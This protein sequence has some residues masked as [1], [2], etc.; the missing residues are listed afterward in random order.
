MALKQMTTKAEIIATLQYTDQNTP[1]AS[2]DN[3]DNT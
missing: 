2:A 1:F 3:L